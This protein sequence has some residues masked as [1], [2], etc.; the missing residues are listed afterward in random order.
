MNEW[1]KVKGSMEVVPS[2][3]VS[4]GSWYRSGTKTYVQDDLRQKF[5][6]LTGFQQDARKLGCH[7]P[8]F[9]LIFHMEV[10]NFYWGTFYHKAHRVPVGF[11]FSFCPFSSFR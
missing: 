9:L 3:S 10:E 7:F 5:H 11:S 2:N 4:M 8:N 6:G 1:V